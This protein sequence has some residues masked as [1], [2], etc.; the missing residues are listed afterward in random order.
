MLIISHN[1]E[2]IRIKKMAPT[3]VT[4]YNL[5]LPRYRVVQND[6]DVYGSYKYYKVNIS[7]DGLTIIDKRDG[8]CLLESYQYLVNIKF[9]DLPW[10][11]LERER[12]FPVQDIIDIN[13]D[14]PYRIT[15]GD[16]VANDLD[17]YN[18]TILL[19]KI[20]NPTGGEIAQDPNGDILF[21]PS[22]NYK[23]LRG[24]DYR[25]KNS[26][27]YITSTNTAV[28]LRDQHLP[29]DEGFFDQ[30]YLRETNVIPVWQRYTGKNISVALVE[31]TGLILRHPDIVNNLKF[32]V[33]Y[34]F[35]THTNIS[36]PLQVAGVIAAARNDIGLV[37]VAYD[38]K[39][40]SYH[41]RDDSSYYNDF[42]AEHDIIN[43][44]WGVYAVYLG[45]ERAYKNFVKNG[46]DGLGGIIIFSSGN[47]K[48]QGDNANFGNPIGQY[49]VVIG[50]MNKPENQ[51]FLGANIDEFAT[52]G[53]NILISAP[54]S[55]FPTLSAECLM[56]A[57]M[58]LDCNY[59]VRNAYGTSFAAPL[60]SGI[61]ALMLE[62]NPNLGWR[63]VQDI[64]AITAIYKDTRSYNF[65]KYESDQSNAGSEN[66]PA[67]YWNKA[68]NHNGGSM[69]FS[70]QYGFGRV[71]AGAAVKL[72]E[73][74]TLKQTSMNHPILTKLNPQSYGGSLRCKKDMSF[75]FQYDEYYDVEYVQ[76]NIDMP[77]GIEKTVQ[78]ITLKSPSGTVSTLL[79]L[80]TKEFP[81]DVVITFKELG[82]TNFRGENTN[83]TWSLFIKTNQ[84]CTE[85]KNQDQLYSFDLK[86]YCKNPS[87][88][89]YY[90]N[91]FPTL[92][93]TELNSS[94]PI[95]VKH[96]DTINTAAV[97]GNVSI[98]LSDESS[99]ISNT[100]V[101]FGKR[102][103]IVNLITG[104]GDDKL[105]GTPKDNIFAPG[106][107]ENYIYTGTGNDKI[108]FPNLHT[109]S[110]VTKIDG[111]T[112][113]VTKLQFGRD[114]DYL[115]IESR[116]VS[117]M[118]N[119]TAIIGDDFEIILIGVGGENIGNDSFIFGNL[120]MP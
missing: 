87:T 12:S 46:R 80:S 50:G 98:D 9:T 55:H 5:Q 23:G 89:L 17:F 60:V 42:S 36:H 31:S 110:G 119:N 101:I 19:H 96:F 106:R 45:L 59:D 75:G 65:E 72:A 77:S 30:W 15:T 18:R 116:M 108:Y 70:Y 93:T 74:W 71:D 40:S 61:V 99:Y 41:V 52:P 109:H 76:T 51:I 1:I 29:K 102:H 20:L 107:G 43:N 83:G 57:S 117:D 62:A 92:K 33:N 32:S 114:I 10:I 34:Q 13:G 100:E 22:S 104:D 64:L 21:T 2:R 84:V 95:P 16:L 44:S 113:A 73:S 69:H 8:W 91:E 11:F 120:I 94:K 90:T 48:M 47:G 24:F 27:G 81:K 4:K 25:I 26:D 3:N 6:L 97:S 88:T 103:K 68:S 58:T 56:M 82:S 39:I 86:L 38:A 105:Y 37:G 85:E 49:I 79:D 118:N 111:F 54:A 66:Y 35:N 53:S 115:Y 67:W 112:P 28:F 63:D 7:E 14:G 78:K